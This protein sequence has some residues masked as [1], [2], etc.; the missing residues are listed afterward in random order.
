[1]GYLTTDKK[2][3][4][5]KTLLKMKAEGEKIA[6][7]TAYDFTTATIFDEAGIDSIHVGDS[8]SNVIAGNAD[9]LPVTVDEMIFMARAVA[10]ACKHAFV[11]CDMPFI[12]IR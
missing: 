6:Q 1:M 12:S 7:L 5:V 2:K 4:T 11:V 3:I 9:T 8:G 10:R